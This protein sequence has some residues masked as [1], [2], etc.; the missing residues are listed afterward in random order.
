MVRL[1]LSL[2]IPDPTKRVAAWLG[3]CASLS[4]ASEAA[5]LVVGALL[6]AL[7]L[8]VIAARVLHL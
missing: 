1:L 8:I 7:Y 6:F 4:F 3:G 5:G 2:G